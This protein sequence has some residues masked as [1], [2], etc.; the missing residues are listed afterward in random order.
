MKFHSGKDI[1]P[2]V[3]AN[4]AIKAFSNEAT[5][6]LSIIFLREL[7]QNA[8]DATYKGIA[9]LHFFIVKVFQ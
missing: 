2:R 8:I 7:I 5:D 6:P 4:T 1:Q 9:R 3:D